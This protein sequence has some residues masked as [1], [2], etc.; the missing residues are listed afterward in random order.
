MKTNGLKI[1]FLISTLLHLLI[2]VLFG[3]VV[4]GVG[5]RE[6]LMKI[7]PLELLQAPKEE[8]PVEVASLVEQEPAI[9]EVVDK[10]IPPPPPSPKVEPMQETPSVPLM[11]AVSPEEIAG[12]EA[13]EEIF[14]EVIV[15]PKLSVPIKALVAEPEIEKAPVEETRKPGHV[16]LVPETKMLQKKA[17][18]SGNADEMRLFKAMVRSRIEEK[19]FYPRWARKNEYE[20]TVGVSFKVMSDGTVSEVKVIR[21]CHF[22]ILNKAACKAVEKAAPFTS[23]PGGLKG[24]A[25]AMEIDIDFRMK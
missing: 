5:K 23:V 16:A 4:S 1:P 19:V 10:V 15:E 17:G 11:E 18:I 24:E 2:L 12:P 8:A 21:P 22:D 9:P 7:I 3:M 20:G 6:P 14:K 25:L 13:V